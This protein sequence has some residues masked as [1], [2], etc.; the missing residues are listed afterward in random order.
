[1]PITSIYKS[2]SL[3]PHPP[4]AIYSQAVKVEP[5]ESC[6][7]FHWGFLN[8]VGKIITAFLWIFDEY[9]TDL[10]GNIFRRIGGYFDNIRLTRT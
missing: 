5:V 6:G 3:V 1:M 7:M 10:K 9:R 2:G 4:K 8:L